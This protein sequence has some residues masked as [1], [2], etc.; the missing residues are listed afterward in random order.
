MNEELHAEFVSRHTELLVNFGQLLDCCDKMYFDVMGEDLIAPTE[1][2]KLQKENIN[3]L[4][5]QLKNFIPLFLEIQKAEQKM[6]L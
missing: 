5:E 6:K 3:T 1:N 2:T 4:S